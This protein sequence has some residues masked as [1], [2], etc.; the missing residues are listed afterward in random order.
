[1]CGGGGAHTW[2]KKTIFFVYLGI[3][4]FVVVVVGIVV[5]SVYLFF[6]KGKLC[7]R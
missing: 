4:C 6:L 5:V 3:I 7:M 1:M 2:E